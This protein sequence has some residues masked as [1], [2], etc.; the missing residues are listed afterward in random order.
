MAN[1]AALVKEDG[2]A[3]LAPIARAIESGAAARDVASI[4]TAAVADAPIVRSFL[5]A[6]FALAAAAA[7]ATL[8][9]P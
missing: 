7:V 2:T 3:G 5:S 4:R 8:A 1:G 6:R 9:V